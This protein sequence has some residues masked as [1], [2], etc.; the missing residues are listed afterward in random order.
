MCRYEILDAGTE[1]ERNPARAAFQPSP[2]CGRAFAG[3]H[4]HDGVDADGDELRPVVIRPL[5]M[6]RSEMLTFTRNGTSG[7]AAGAVVFGV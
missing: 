6:L 7:D 1:V 2:A 3:L 5:R 4:L